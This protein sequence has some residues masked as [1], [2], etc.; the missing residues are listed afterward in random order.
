MLTVGIGRRQAERIQT[1]S[2]YPEVQEASS[3]YLENRG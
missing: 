3:E 1:S 2:G